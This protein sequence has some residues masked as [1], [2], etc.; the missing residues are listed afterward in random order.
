[1]FAAQNGTPHSVRQ[2]VPRLHGR[3]QLD[4]TAAYAIVADANAT[5]GPAGSEIPAPSPLLRTAVRIVKLALEA[6]ALLALVSLFFIRL[7]QVDGHS[8][9]PHLLA[10]EHVL[11]NTAAYDLRFGSGER[12]LFDI[13][14]APIARGDVIAFMHAADGP[15]QVYLKRV[16]G[17]PGDS[18]SIVLGTVSVNGHQLAEPYVVMGDRTTMAATRVPARSVFVLGD[19]RGESDDSRSFGAVPRTAVIGRAG[20]VVWPL[21]RAARIR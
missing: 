19:N 5:S 1:M 20:L 8:M 4:P 15:P 18:V 12:P 10:G 3:G 9:E 13:A 17:L 11:I 6:T 14:L 21:N 2:P 16:I 7:P